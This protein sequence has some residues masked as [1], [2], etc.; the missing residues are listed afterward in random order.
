MFNL[1][2]G[3]FFIFSVFGTLKMPVLDDTLLLLMGISSATFTTLKALQ[4]NALPQGKTLQVQPPA[5]DVRNLPVTPPAAVDQATASTRPPDD[6]VVK[7]EG[8]HVQ[9]S[10][11]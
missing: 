6:L 9:L 3:F 4:A 5:P 2:I 10:L 1:V 8:A 7:D 11:G